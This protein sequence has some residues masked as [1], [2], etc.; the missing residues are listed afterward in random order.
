MPND[1][2]ALAL[3]LLFCSA[4]LLFWDVLPTVSAAGKMFPKLVCVWCFGVAF[5]VHN[6]QTAAVLG[7]LWAAAFEL[8]RKQPFLC[9]GEVSCGATVV[10]PCPLCAVLCGPLKLLFPQRNLGLPRAESTLVTS[11]KA[12]PFIWSSGTNYLHFLLS[13]RWC[14][15][16]PWMELQRNPLPPFQHHSG[17]CLQ[18]SIE[19]LLSNTFL[20]PL[21]PDDRYYS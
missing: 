18:G 4:A 14:F 16:L 6:T 5:S 17:F 2:T 20:L 7:T 21:F 15:L 11:C 10:S 9:R 3:W 8:S 1:T 13:Q 12:T 19:L